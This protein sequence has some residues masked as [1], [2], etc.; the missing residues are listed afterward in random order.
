MLVASRGCP[1]STCIS[2]VWL[3]RC[4]LSRSPSLKLPCLPSL[5]SIQ[6]CIWAIGC[7][8][9]CS[10]SI[11]YLSQQGKGM[12]RRAVCSVHARKSNTQDSGHTH[13]MH[14]M[15]LRAAR[16]GQSSFVSGCPT[17]VIIARGHTG[18]SAVGAIIAGLYAYMY[19]AV[20]FRQP[21][22]ASA[23]MHNEDQSLMPV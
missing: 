10:P 8:V 12:A 4:E 20:P 6:A 5:C 19:V 7:S 3:E 17:E 22:M 15:K 1:G 18:S 21:D 14:P 13:L 11:P 9:P 2:P 16:S 23:A